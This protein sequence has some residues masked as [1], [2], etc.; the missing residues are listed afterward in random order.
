MVALGVEEIMVFI[1]R[2]PPTSACPDERCNCVSI[3]GMT[4][5]EGIVVK[6]LTIRLA[7]EC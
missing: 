3:E 7:G 6:H 2:L 1:F 4:G 5:D